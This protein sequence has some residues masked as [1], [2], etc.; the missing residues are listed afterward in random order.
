MSTAEPVTVWDVYFQFFLWKKMMNMRT[1]KYLE[2]SGL[3]TGILTQI[4]FVSMIS[5]CVLRLLCTLEV[6]ITA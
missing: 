5:N 1:S 6:C 3:L 4:C 2:D